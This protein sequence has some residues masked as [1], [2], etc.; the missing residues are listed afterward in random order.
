MPDKT[1]IELDG[2]AV[3]GKG[4]TEA[5]EELEGKG[6]TVVVDFRNG[7]ATDINASY[8]EKVEGRIRLQVMEDKVARFVVG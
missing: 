1:Q 5:V 2:E 4:E 7:E 6:H 3:V 8:N